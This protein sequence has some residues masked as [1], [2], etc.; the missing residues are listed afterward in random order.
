MT[1]DEA[2]QKA[3]FKPNRGNAATLKANQSI[4]DRVTELQSKAAKKAE[5]TVDS[6]A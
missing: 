5:I 4:L 1:A 6:L 3:G 2:Y